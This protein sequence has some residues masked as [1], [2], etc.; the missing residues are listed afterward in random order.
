MPAS[1]LAQSRVPQSLSASS[2]L[3]R[4]SLCPAL[5]SNSLVNRRCWE[6]QVISIRTLTFSLFDC[7]KRIRHPHRHRRRCHP[8]GCRG[9]RASDK[10]MSSHAT[11][12]THHRQDF[13]FPTSFFLTDLTA[14]AIWMEGGDEDADNECAA[15]FTPSLLSQRHG[16]NFLLFMLRFECTAYP[17]IECMQQ[18]ER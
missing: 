13:L 3:S 14:T 1:S 11:N 2:S 5:F 7:G 10:R 12:K 8:A 15:Y 16:S 9:L 6:N 18:T 17:G 4:S